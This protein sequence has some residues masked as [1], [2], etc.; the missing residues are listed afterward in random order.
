MQN[1]YKARLRRPIREES[2]TN[3]YE[4]NTRKRKK[5]YR[6]DRKS[7]KRHYVSR[8][9]IGKQERSPPDWSE[10]KDPEMYK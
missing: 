7:Y 3:N 4:S 2:I 6:A 10:G 1:D 8:R 5:Y 9:R